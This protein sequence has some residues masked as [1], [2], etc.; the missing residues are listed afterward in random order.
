MGHSDDTLSWYQRAL[1]ESQSAHIAKDAR[2]A[3]LEA[4]LAEARRDGERLEFMMKSGWRVVSTSP[5]G[6][7][8]LKDSAGDFRTGWYDD[9][10]YAIDAARGA[11]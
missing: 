1:R 6:D 3:A 5:K 10:R 8:R 9:P 11:K 2:I 4:E 7:Y